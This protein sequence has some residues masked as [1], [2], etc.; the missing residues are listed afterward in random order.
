MQDTFIFSSKNHTKMKK[1]IKSHPKALLITAFVMGWALALFLHHPITYVVMGIFTFIVLIASGVMV[2]DKY[3]FILLLCG[4]FSFAGHAQKTEMIQKF[5]E[6]IPRLYHI[7]RIDIDTFYAIEGVEAWFN[8]HAYFSTSSVSVEYQAINGTLE[9][10]WMLDSI[11]ITEKL[12]TLEAGD[13]QFLI[14]VGNLRLYFLSKDAGDERLFANCL[15]LQV[16]FRDRASR[17]NVSGDYLKPAVKKLS[18]LPSGNLLCVYENENGEEI[19]NL[20][21]FANGE[22]VLLTLISSGQIELDLK[23]GGKGNAELMRA[24]SKRRSFRIMF[25]KSLSPP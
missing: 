12:Y 2:C 3:F 15:L 14:E 22:D 6:I 21:F 19:F 16:N 17:K 25:F 10:T 7:E 13:N 8:N 11:P 23:R 18:R 5:E 24:D 9:M 1:F 20:I 4:F